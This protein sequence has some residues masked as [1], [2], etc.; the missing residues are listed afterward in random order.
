EIY[1]KAKA[2][3]HSR[4]GAEVAAT[5]QRTNASTAVVDAVF[6]TADADARD[7]LKDVLTAGDSGL[8]GLLTKPLPSVQIN[9]A[10]LTHELTRK[11]TLEITLPRFNFQTQSVTTAL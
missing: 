2:A 4:Y 7:L 1:D 9:G 11:S 6:D 3:L 10:V 5:W 8:D